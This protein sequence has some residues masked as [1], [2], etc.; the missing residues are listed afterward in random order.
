MFDFLFGGTKKL[1]LIRELMEQRVRNMGYDSIEYNLK[2][3]QLGNMQLIGSPEG[4]IVTIIET[5]FK[6]QKQNLLIQAILSKIEGHRKL[7]GQNINIFYTIL[8]MTNGTT[9]EASNAIVEYTRYRVN[10]EHPGKVSDDQFNDTFAK[11]SEF[12]FRN[13]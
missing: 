13:A 1:S 4:T 7:S 2:I 12:L 5:V 8:S 3:K 11:A 10:L 6:L 9:Q